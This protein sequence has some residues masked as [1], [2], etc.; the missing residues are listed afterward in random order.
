LNYQRYTYVD[1]G[2]VAVDLTL[3]RP[4]RQ[5]VPAASGIG[6][7]VF[8]A[9]LVPA[10][11]EQRVDYLI[12]QSLRFTEAEYADVEKL[13][14]HARRGTLVTV[15][16][17]AAGA[18]RACYASPEWARALWQGGIRPRVSDFPG[19]FEIETE[20]VSTSGTWAGTKFYG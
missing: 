12:K 4:G 15:Y 7:I 20:W 19:Q 10:S 6:G 1:S 9:A 13:L 16:P 3:S 8:S 11:W 18:G 17:D 5:W 14:E 2:S